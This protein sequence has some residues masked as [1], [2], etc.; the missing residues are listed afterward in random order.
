MIDNNN[1]K[2]DSD[3]EFI[4]LKVYKSIIDKVI[5]DLK[6]TKRLNQDYSPNYD[7]I[8]VRFRDM[9]ID[10]GSHEIL[11]KAI[12]ST[13]KTSVLGRDEL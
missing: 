11:K 6:E 12:I 3:I 8:L 9:I 7:L 5:N 4:V 1:N 13:D 10:L 2:D